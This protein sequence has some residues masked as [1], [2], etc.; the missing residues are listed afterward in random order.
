[1]NIYEDEAL[2]QKLEEITDLVGHLVLDI[3]LV[4]LRKVARENQIFR[5]FAEAKWPV[6]PK[7]DTW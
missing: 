4:S 2:E 7:T 6:P 1:M 3:L 5:D